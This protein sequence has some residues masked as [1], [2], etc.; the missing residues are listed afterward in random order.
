[1][2]IT[3]LHHFSIIA[4][5]N[6]SVEFY[7]R[8]GFTETRRIE[9]AYDTVVLM[10]GYGIGLELFIDPSHSRSTTQPLGFRSLSLKADNLEQIDG[11]I[12]KDWNG[13]RYV[14]IIDPDGNIIQLHE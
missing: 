1:M 2:G 12:I 5:S 8:L 7:T 6:R 11:E 14:Q 3:G 4:S 13:E 9:R 10:E